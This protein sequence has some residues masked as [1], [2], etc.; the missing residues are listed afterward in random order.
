[1]VA[2]RNI[3]ME[4]FKAAIEQSKIKRAQDFQ[5][6]GLLLQSLRDQLER[7]SLSPPQK[8]QVVQTFNAQQDE[9]LREARK[10]VTISDFTF[11]RV[12]GAGAFG[13]VRLCRKKDTGQVFALKQMRK[14]EMVRKNQLR[15]LR[16][17]L[18]ALSGAQDDWV[19]GLHYTFQDDT[20][21]YMVMDYL[22]GGDLMT[23]LQRKDT[24]T[25]AETR[26]YIAEI[27]EAVDYIHTKLHCIHRDIK[28]DNIVLDAKGHIRLVDFG[29][30]KHSPPQPAA[31]WD[32]PVASRR[33]QPD[34]PLEA[35][36]SPRSTCHPPRVQ[37]QSFGTPDYM[38][39]E[40]YRREPCGKECDWWSVGIVMFEMLFGG[41]PFSDEHHDPVVTARRVR[42]WWQHF[43]MPEDPLVGEAARELLRGLIC[44]PEDRLDANGIRSHRFF[45]GVDFSK[46]RQ[47][48]P[49]IKPVVKGILD[50]SNFPDCQGV[51]PRFRITTS[52]RR[53][54]VKD[55]TLFAFHDYSYRRDLKAKKPCVATAMA[56][57][58]APSAAHKQPRQKWRCS[59]LAASV[60]LLCPGGLSRAF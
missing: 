5:E 13:I 53:Q 48:E 49:P 59:A 36:H 4:A 46:L 51:E 41:P 39:P 23:Y 34:D 55:A 20:F 31:G 19:I 30:C 3:R 18:R 58:V 42:R 1:M 26:F 15:H 47:M 28:P 54:A 57:A 8:E 35:L 24:F 33:S 32:S 44:D 9:Y 14:A 21:L 25:E 29:L 38:G 27:V 16:A 50:T 56:A 6:R 40:A 22:P 2:D 7:N 17:E 60:A 45:E 10:Q 43:Y 37:L 11:V 12:I 52:S